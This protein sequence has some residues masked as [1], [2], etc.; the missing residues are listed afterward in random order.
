MEKKQNISIIGA[1]MAGCFMAICL[2]KRGYAVSIYES[3][4]DV[5]KEP[6]DSGRSFNIT[7]YYRGMQAMKQMGIWESIKKVAIHAEGNVPHYYG[8]KTSFDPFDK[9]GREVL[10]TVH[11]N[12]LNGALLDEVEKFANAKVFF[13]T[14]CI[15]I[16]REKKVLTFEKD[17]KT[18]TTHADIIIGADGVNSMVRDVLQKGQVTDHTKEYEDWGY[19]EVHVPIGLA[20]QLHLRNNATHTWPRNNSLLLAFPNP[21]KSLT[22]MFNLPLEG[23]ESFA[24]LTSEATIKDYITKYFPDLLPILPEITHA[25]LHK[26]TGNFVTVLTSPWYYKES[27][28]IIGDAAHG[29]TPFYGQGVS[30]AFE[31]CLLLSELIEKYTNNIEEAFSKF[32]R[33]RKKNT[34]VLAFLS[35]ENFLELRDRSRSPYH[36]L[37]AK[38]NTFLHMIIPSLWLPPLYYLVAHDTV[39]YKKAY[40]MHQ[41]QEKISKWIGL[42][43]LIKVGAVPFALFRMLNKNTR[44]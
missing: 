34:D 1:G 32:Q 31:D 39:A 17:K 41:R 10:Y 13:N 26:P 25:I 7:L 14:D 11:R 4:P 38:V 36:L 35:R 30:A 3:R 40:E 23:E 6:Y 19:K 42:N 15:G 8:R 16:D 21:D 27:M 5:R 22:L 9:K 29:V 33:S 28:V 43:L 18:I 12:F 24:S 20:E 37:K 2:A 44:G